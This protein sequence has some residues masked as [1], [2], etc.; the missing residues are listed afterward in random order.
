MKYFLVLLL[1]VSFSACGIFQKTPTKR[2][3]SDTTVMLYRNYV[4]KYSDGSDLYIYLP[5]HYEVNKY[6]GPDFT[7]FYYEF[8]S[9]DSA[10]GYIGWAGE[11]GGFAA[12]KTYAEEDETYVA[13][14]SDT[15]SNGRITEWNLYCS[16][17]LWSLKTAKR[18][19]AWAYAPTKR[20]AL[21][22]LDILKTKVTEP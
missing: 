22:W 6:E 7:T 3:A 18:L 11:Y 5:K 17:T 4:Q 8:D 14:I 21:M 15:L 10:D 12:Q 2:L 1:A 13:S 9:K 20:S 19:Y 16:R